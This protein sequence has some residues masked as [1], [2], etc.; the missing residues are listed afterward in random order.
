MFA[1]ICCFASAY[2]GYHYSQTM[3]KKES[4]KKV[5]TKIKNSQI[6]LA[7]DQ[8]N[9][10]IVID[11]KTGDYIIYEDTVGTTIFSLY[12]KNLWVNQ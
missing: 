9:N 2:I 7:V 12:A 5:T 8:N 4:E 1:A 11:K 6:N 10:L 3:A